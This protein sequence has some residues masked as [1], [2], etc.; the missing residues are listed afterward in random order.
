MFCDTGKI[1]YATIKE[2]SVAVANLNKQDKKHK[3]NYYKCPHCKM[4]HTATV[5]S[6]KK[7]LAQ[8]KVK[9]KFRYVPLLKYEKISRKQLKPNKMETQNA[10]S[11]PP[12]KGESRVRTKFNAVIPGEARTNVDAIKQD[13][14]GLIDFCESGIADVKQND[15]N[16][17]AKGEAIRLWSLAQTAYE[18][19][20][21]WAVKAATYGL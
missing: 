2:A 5:K 12:T 4:F 19:A 18:E 6:G 16:E 3:H 1:C 11:P 7:K 15:W 8:K 14:A 21:M 13:S 9:Y 17:G 20:A 10:V